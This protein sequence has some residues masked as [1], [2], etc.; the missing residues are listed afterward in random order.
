MYKHLIFWY[1]NVV[2]VAGGPSLFLFQC[3]KCGCAAKLFVQ[4][5][6]KSQIKIINKY[7]YEC[8]SA[9]ASATVG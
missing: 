4:A 8:T 7:K 6:P 1:C 5:C 9:S 2:L 3:F